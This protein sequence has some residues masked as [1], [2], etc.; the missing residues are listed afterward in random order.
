MAVKSIPQADT[1]MLQ[2]TYIRKAVTACRKCSLALALLP[3][4]VATADEPQAFVGNKP[5]PSLVDAVQAGDAGAIDAALQANRDVNEPQADGMS[6]LHWAVLRDDTLLTERLLEAGAEP[7]AKNIYGVPPLAVACINGNEAIVRKLLA[8]GADPQVRLAGEETMLMLAAR[9]GRLPVVEA[10]LEAGLAVDARERQQQTAM[11][12]AAA[13]GHTSVVE[14]LIAAGAD[15]RQPLDSGFTPLFFAIR[16]GHT[17]TALAL[18]QHELDI[19]EPMT[20]RKRQRGPTPLLLAVENGHFETAAALL[21]AGADPNLQPDGHAALHAIS[22]VRKPLRGDGDPAPVGSGKLGSLE[23]VRILVKHGADVNLQLKR[24]KAGFARL[25]TTGATP[26]FLAAGT[27]DM[28]LIKLLLELG[29]DPSIVNADQA[30][31][32]LAAAGVGD[33]GSGLEFAGTEAEAIAVTELLIELG[34]EVNIVDD[35]G[36]TVM[37]GAA[38]QNWPQ[39]I[40]I[41]ADRGAE[42][43]VWNRQNKWGWTPLMIAQGY[44]EGN[45]RPDPATTEAIERHLRAAGIEPMA[46]H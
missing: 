4:F 5:T 28:P 6:A 45:F 22:W 42:A 20:S 3:A 1:A 30:S 40:D 29:A 32:L 41:L 26:L 34:L 11:M 37:H 21:K 16:Q 7:A 46:S 2:L 35:N 9:T 17:E 33:L 13:E 8:A 10:L 18:L 19:D 24:G 23:F 39:L 31:P 25:S 12:W 14:R 15:Y 27:G 43:R 44:R 38:Y 36:E